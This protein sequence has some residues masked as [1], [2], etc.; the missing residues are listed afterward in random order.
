M[1]FI[2][3]DGW[4]ISAAIKFSIKNTRMYDVH[5]PPWKLQLFLLTPN[6]N[7]DSSDVIYLAQGQNMFY[8]EPFHSWIY[9]FLV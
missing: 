7:F 9:C 6:I 8:Q 4:K 5:C 1:S 3:S 2:L